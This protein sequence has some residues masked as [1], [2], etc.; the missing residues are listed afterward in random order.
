M[1]YL[2]LTASMLGCIILAAYALLNTQSH[3]ELQKEIARLTLALSTAK[4]QIAQL[5]EKEKRQRATDKPPIIVLPEADGF[6][7]QQ[8]SAELLLYLGPRSGD[9]V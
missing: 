9:G 4:G 8:G 1:I 7:F 5:G 6:F 3:T 2:L